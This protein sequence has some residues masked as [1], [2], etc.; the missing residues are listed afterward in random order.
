MKSMKRNAAAALCTLAAVGAGAATPSPEEMWAIIQKQQAQ[1]EALQSQLAEAGQR[2]EE[3]DVKVEATADLIEE[4]MEPVSMASGVGKMSFGG[5]G[6]LH[7]NNLDNNRSGGSDKKQLDL[8][9][10]VMFTGYQFSER[11]RFYSELEVEHALV[12]GGED[13][14]EVE[15]EQA[16]IEHDFG[17]N[18]RMKAGLFL[19]PVGILNETHEPDTFYGVER[20]SVESRIIPSTWWEG[21]LAASGEI[22]PGLNYD[23]ALTSGLKL[24][25]EEGKWSIRDGRQK[26]AEADASDL[27]WTARLKYTGLAGLE[28]GATL[29]YQEDLYQGALADT[30]DALLFEAHVAYQAGPFGLRA[31]AASWDI[32][33]GIEAIRV[34][35]DRQE[36]WYVEPSW[37]PLKNLG[38]FARYSEWDNQAGGGGDTE[39]SQWDVGLNYWLEDTVVFKFDYQVQDTPD[40]RD[41]FD[42]F[43]LGVGWSY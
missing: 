43:N 28:L 8:H 10:F 38:L 33:D 18:Q 1:I 12:E 37:R 13:S 40:G 30:V 5:Y 24:D 39:Y 32:D 41:E 31:L 2:L 4:R 29:Q 21:G 42:G 11:T 14:G 34:G 26:V 22:M 3:T 9:R 7:Y 17:G 16:F 25:A 35:A 15:I 20:N 6:E 23:A 19:V 27:A 36:G